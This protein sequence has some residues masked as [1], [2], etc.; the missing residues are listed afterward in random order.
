MFRIRWWWVSLREQGAYT[1]LDTGSGC[2][3]AILFLAVSNGFVT[4]EYSRPC[5][6]NR[7]YLA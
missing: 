3:N 1:F 4:T 7:G 6:R 5:T 2:W